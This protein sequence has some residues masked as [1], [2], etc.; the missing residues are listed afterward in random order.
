MEVEGDEEDV[1]HGRGHLVNTLLDT[2]ALGINGNYISSALADKIDS[3][4]SMR[5]VASDVL[6]CSG[7][8]GVCSK[9]N[10]TL[11]LTVK[12]K[13][14]I[15]ITLQ[16]TI[17]NKTP[18]DLI[19]GK[20]AIVMYGLLNIFPEIFGIHTSTKSCVECSRFGTH[21]M[22]RVRTSNSANAASEPLG[23]G[24]RDCAPRRNARAPY[25]HS[26]GI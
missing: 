5:Q 15:F 25:R 8:D 22:Q 1:G 20:E 23:R 13:N 19:I 10:N 12:I 3:T 6:V 7:V 24:G 11:N 18:I 4:K 14:H 17:L 2:G 21:T 16:F 9:A 26:T